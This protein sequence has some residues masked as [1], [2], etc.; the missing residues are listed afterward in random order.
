MLSR[1]GIER[2]KIEAK[3]GDLDKAFGFV[4]RAHKILARG[5]PTHASAMAGLYNQGCVRQQQGRLEEALALFNEAMSLAQL[6]EA[7][8]GNDGET[9]RIKRRIGQIF[10]KLGKKVEGEAYLE[11]AGKSKRTLEQT[12]D[13]PQGLEGDES[14]DIFLGLLY[15]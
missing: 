2:G 5:K 11:T 3:I 14:W 10:E 7:N 12:G 6:N 9:V 13:Y 8:R 4:E 15:R 1:C